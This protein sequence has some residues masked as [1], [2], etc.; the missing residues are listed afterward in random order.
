MKFVNAL[1]L[2][3]N[4]E[5]EIEAAIS[6]E[7]EEVS[8]LLTGLLNF[9]KSILPSVGSALLVLFIGMMLAKALMKIIKRTLKRT[10]IDPTAGSF[11]TS[12]ISVLLYVIVAVIVL[13]VLNVPMDSIVTVIG[14]A[15]LAI[16]LALQD[17]LANVAGGFLIMF[18][19]PLKVG[20]L[21]K[22]GDVTGTVKSVGILQTQLVLGDQTV[23]F[24]PNGQVAESVIVNYS[25]KEM[26]RLDLEIGISYDADFE[27]AKQVIAELIQAHPLAAE[28]PA[29]LVRVGRFDDS[30][31]VLFVKVWTANDH[32]WDLHYDMHEQIK[33]AFD[34]NGISMPY[35]QVDVHMA[36]KD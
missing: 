22:F 32:Y 24:I 30:A 15:G 29:P 1:F 20:D 3:Q 10:T 25:E 21:V 7:A 31:V 12:V 16:G 8:T 33:K 23:V 26:R 18:T 36:G 35:P 11:L 5:T 6:Q 17:S 13:S 2:T 34:A 28:D 4:T 27:K 9:I 19:K 14:T